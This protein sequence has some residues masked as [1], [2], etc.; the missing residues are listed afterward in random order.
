MSK[1]QLTVILPV[2]NSEE[3][4]AP[5]IRSV[6]NQTFKEFEL[7][8]LENG[9][10]DRTAQVVR[11]INDSRIKLF[12]LGPV[13][14]QGALQ[15]AIENAPTEWLARMDADDLMFPERL[16]IQLDFIHRN[17]DIVFI[18]T[19]YALLTPFGHVFEP[20]VTLGTR[21]VTKESLAY[22]HRFF[23]DPTV[24]FNRHAALRAGGADFNFPKVDGVPLLFRLL[25]QGK[26]WEIAKHLHLYRVRPAS[27]SRSNEHLE[28]AYRVRLKYAPEFIKAATKPPQ[29]QS[30]WR[31]IAGLE[32]LS[33][34]MRSMRCAIKRMRQD[35]ASGS[36][37]NALLLR[38]FLGGAGS[39]YYRWRNRL[40][41]RHRR[42]WE[43]LFLALIDVKRKNL[44]IAGRK[45]S[46]TNI[47][48]AGLK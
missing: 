32:L 42:D 21:E 17:P 46:Y 16:Q 11:S 9:S 40:R 26:G 7:W 48:S 34:D 3:F 18:G 39:A 1:S 19:A 25:T 6:L 27:L 45:S 33:G 14:V 37:A 13:G 35:G 29:Q 43:Q 4:I 41:Y 31:S 12:Q 5:A 2:R 20:K 23:G 44:P 30:V 28:Q 15:Y 8:V 36:E 22:N 10:E 24:V 47:P 38:S